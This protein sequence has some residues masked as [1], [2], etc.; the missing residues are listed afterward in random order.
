[1]ASAFVI[2]AIQRRSE[3]HFAQSRAPGR[4]TRFIKPSSQ[5]EAPTSPAVASTVHVSDVALGCKRAALRPPR[6]PTL[7]SIFY[8]PLHCCMCI[9]PEGSPRGLQTSK[10]TAE[11]MEQ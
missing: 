3:P 2:A 7:N 10:K 6:A 11:F 4:N 8:C 5:K 1:M 9:A